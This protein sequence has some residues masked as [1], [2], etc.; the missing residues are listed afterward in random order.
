M[1]DRR[2]M[3]EREAEER[4]DQLFKETEEELGRWAEEVKEKAERG[5]T[6]DFDYN[7]L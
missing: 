4:W 3:A 7:R 5:E 6:E 1:E 2:E